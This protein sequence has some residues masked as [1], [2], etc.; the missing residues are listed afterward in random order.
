MGFWADLNRLTG[1]LLHGDLSGALDDAGDIAEGTMGALGLPHPGQV[2]PPQIS[3]LQ[4][5]G[6]NQSPTLPGMMGQIQ[7][8]RTQGKPDAAKETCCNRFSLRDGFLVD[9]VTGRVWQFNTAAGSFN[10]VA[11]EN[12]SAKQDL[13]DSMLEGKLSVIRAQYEQEVLATVP[14]P[15]RAA[16]LTQFEK[17]HLD[18]LR[19]A[20]QGVT[21]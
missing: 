10:E 7:P 18:P 12:S 21:Y 14:R 6:V 19:A 9:G 5:G 3:P 2:S 13:A 8:G 1:H 15:K 20:A 17:D 16:L 11:V 4:I